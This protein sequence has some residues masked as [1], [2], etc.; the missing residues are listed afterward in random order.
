MKPKPNVTS[1]FTTALQNRAITELRS[2]ADHCACTTAWSQTSWSFD[3]PVRTGDVVLSP[4]RS[5]TGRC[6]RGLTVVV[7]I[8]Q[9]LN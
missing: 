6:E 8:L 9:G 5:K 1:M 4:G 3:G 2:I 7:G